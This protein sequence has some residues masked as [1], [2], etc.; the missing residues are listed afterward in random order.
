VGT[1]DDVR[2][3]EG[4]FAEITYQ[5]ADWRNWY[6]S[7]FRARRSVILGAVNKGWTCQECEL[8]FLDVTAAVS[9]L[10]LT[11]SQDQ[12]HGRTEGL[13]RLRADYKA[14]RDYASRNP[15]YQSAAEARQRIG[16]LAGDALVYPWNGRTGRTDRDVLAAL[17]KMATKAGTDAVDASVRDLSI[18]SGVT[19]RTVSRSLRRLSD[20]GWIKQVERA[21][22]GAARYKLLSPQRVRRNYTHEPEVPL[23]E[24]HVCRNGAK[25]DPGHEVWVQLGKAS[26]AL[27]R[28]LDVAPQSARHL[29][30][31]A[32]VGSRT[33][34]RKLPVMG[35]LG[36]ATKSD[37]GWAFGT[38]SPDDVAKA[39]GWTEHRSK[40]GR[41]KRQIDEDRERFRLIREGYRPSTCKS[42]GYPF[43]EGNVC[44]DCGVLDDETAA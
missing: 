5:G 28:V 43:K 2:R 8:V 11:G 13:K 24:S 18:L 42:C 26:L 40:T 38:V 6:G 41:R 29:A 27:Y 32:K 23:A 22:P 4:R 16:E 35:G 31:Q 1:Q 10:W 12:D 44:A 25:A 14:M 34:D 20:L 21:S 39:E 3:L 17:H 9:D 7:K 37:H 19:I 33:A 36:L 30:K 15:L